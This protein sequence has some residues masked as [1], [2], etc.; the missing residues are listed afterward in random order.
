MWTPRASYEEA[1]PG[2]RLLPSSRNWWA[3]LKGV[4]AECVHLYDEQSFMASLVPDT[5]YV[6]GKGGSP[7]RFRDS[8]RIRE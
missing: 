7:F 6:R 2:I 1:Y 8:S 4:P 5:L 3:K